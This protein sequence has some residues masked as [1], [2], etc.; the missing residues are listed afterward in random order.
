MQNAYMQKTDICKG[1]WSPN[2]FFCYKLEQII[3]NEGKIVV[4][5]QIPVISW[6]LTC[7]LH[8][9]REDS[10]FTSLEDWLI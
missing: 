9:S 6:W 10:C 1:F 8:P 3:A 5:S 4:L 7:A 2:N